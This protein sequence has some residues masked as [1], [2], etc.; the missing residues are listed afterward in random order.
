[1]ISYPPP[2]LSVIF[3]STTGTLERDGG[4]GSIGA[5]W[6]LLGKFLPLFIDIIFSRQLK[7]LTHGLFPSFPS[8]SPVATLTGRGEASIPFFNALI[9]Y[10]LLT[11]LL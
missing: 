8:P 7:Y 5:T 2:L 4:Y 3:S 1:M 11:N 6:R 9:L 10:A